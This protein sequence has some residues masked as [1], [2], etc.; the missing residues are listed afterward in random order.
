MSPVPYLNERQIY[1]CQGCGGW[2]YWTHDS[3]PCGAC[4][5]RARK[6]WI[7]AQMSGA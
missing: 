5:R 4:N 1:R 6:A 2:R 3:G 7:T